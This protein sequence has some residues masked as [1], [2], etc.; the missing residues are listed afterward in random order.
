M[1]VFNTLT[2]PVLMLRENRIDTDVIFPAR[3]L[4]LMQRDG[5]GEY[6]CRDRRRDAQGSFVA[7]AIDDA[8]VQGA[9]ILLAGKDFGCGS[10]REQAVWTILDFGI[11]CVIAESFGEIFAA[12]CV[13]N[14]VLPIVLDAA[15]IDRLETAARCG[16]LTIDLVGSTISWGGPDAGSI[17]FPIAANDRE[18]LLNGWDETAMITCRWQK[19]IIR[20][21]TAQ[22]RACPWLYEES[23]L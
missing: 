4:L 18:R 16:G 15:A 2:A 1:N 6:F 7:N 8:A 5:L 14:G 3:F 19:D 17:P 21:E 12:N 11:T 22:R 23:C 9:G 10:S 13:R 20:F